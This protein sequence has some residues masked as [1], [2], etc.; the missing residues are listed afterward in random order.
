MTSVAINGPQW[1]ESRSSIAQDF[2]VLQAPGCACVRSCST[3]GPKEARLHLLSRPRR[4]R[5][6]NEWTN[7]RAVTFIVTLAATRSVTLAARAAGMSRK[8][9][10]MLK[11]RDRT[12]AAAWTRAVAGHKVEEVDGSPG[13]KSQRNRRAQCK[14]ARKP[15][16]PVFAWFRS[17]WSNSPGL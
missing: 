13:R 16:S 12:F 4:P 8:S 15:D 7:D 14:A 17:E 11:E 1:V 3:S 5:R 9:A 10:Y 6:A 2:A